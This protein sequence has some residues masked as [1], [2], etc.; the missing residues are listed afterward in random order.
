MASR[1]MSTLRYR[2][3]TVLSAKALVVTPA[4]RGSL[5]SASAICPAMRPSSSRSSPITFTPIGVR[6]PVLSMS[7]RVRIGCVHEFVSPGTRTASLSP[8]TASVWSPVS[9]M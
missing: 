1:S 6:M 4:V 7:M 3:P 8:G 9:T 5:R 2:P